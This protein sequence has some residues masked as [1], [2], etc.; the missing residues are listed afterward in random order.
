[1]VAAF[2]AIL[3]VTAGIVTVWAWSRSGNAASTPSAEAMTPIAEA[4]ASSSTPRVAAAPSGTDHNWE[5]IIGTGTS[6]TCELK[7][8]ATVALWSVSSQQFVVAYHVSHHDAKVTRFRVVDGGDG[9]H[10]GLWSLAHEQFIRMT[11]SGVVELNPQICKEA[12]L[13]EASERHAWQEERFQVKGLEDGHFALLNTKYSEY[14]VGLPHSSTE[15]ASGQRA[16]NII[17]KSQ[18]NQRMAAMPHKSS[19]EAFIAV[20]AHG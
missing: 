19:P 7:P 14:V 3:V 18:T 15:V 6:S 9:V 5:A 8:G 11:K 16:I 2:V 10:I 13:S 1:M 17:G 20:C 4:A 12:T